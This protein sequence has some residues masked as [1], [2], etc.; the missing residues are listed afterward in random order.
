M[1]AGFLGT[2]LPKGINATCKNMG[3]VP[4]LACLARDENYDSAVEV[5]L[6]NLPKPGWVYGEQG[7]RPTQTPLRALCVD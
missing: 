3:F 7:I 6:A 4:A 1:S 2:Q 5:L